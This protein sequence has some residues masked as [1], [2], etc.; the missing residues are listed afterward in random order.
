MTPALERR[1]M[2]VEMPEEI[3]PGDPG[4][5]ALRR[6]KQVSWLMDNAV[7]VPGTD[8][9]IGLDPIVGLLPGAG[10]TAAALV[11]LYVVAEAY[12]LDVPRDVLYRMGFNIAVDYLVG[13]IPIAG[14]LFDVAWRA[15]ERNAR[16]LEQ[17]I[18]EGDVSESGDVEG[19][20]VE[21][22]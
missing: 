18:V 1:G 14:D 7:R 20:D 6:V 16:L 9:R 21:I 19:V 15:N 4:Y 22:E 5:R 8:V 13:V 17:A 12:F 11:S 2:D 3:D 10:D